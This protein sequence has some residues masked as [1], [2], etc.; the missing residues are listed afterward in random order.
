[1][2]ENQSKTLKILIGVI[3][4]LSTIILLSGV[5]YIL[6]MQNKISKL[7]KEQ[8]EQL[9]RQAETQ[10]MASIQTIQPQ[11]NEKQQPQLSQTNTTNK[12]ESKTKTKK[13]NS[14]QNK[15]QNSN[16]RSS[17]KRGSVYATKST[18][19]PVNVRAEPTMNSE[20]IERLPDD[21][22]LRYLSSKGNWYYVVYNVRGYNE[23]GYIHKSQL[24]R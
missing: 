4:G 11:Q 1:M 20:I 10:N 17:V 12:S 13:I 2:K 19:G 23:Y 21:I 16:T 5:F 24:A 15:N 3:I 6:N 22:A 14:N 8:E 7:E 9:K 18:S